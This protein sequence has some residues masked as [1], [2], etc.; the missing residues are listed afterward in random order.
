MPLP[1]ITEKIVASTKPLSLGWSLL[2]LKDIRTGSARSGG[3]NYF[4]EF[5]AISG[6]NS[7]DENKGRSV[8]MLIN[9]GALESGISEACAAY[10]GC[11]CALTNSTEADVTGAELDENALKGSKCWADVGQR[12]VDGKTYW[13]FRGFSPATEVPF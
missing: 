4:F 10:T 2:E 13:D 6:P 5:E 12:I 7:S 3:T 11:I 8:T 1:K 9:G